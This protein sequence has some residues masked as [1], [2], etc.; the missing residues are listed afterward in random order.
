[1]TNWKWKC[2]F[3]VGYNHSSEHIDYTL[4]GS[5]SYLDIKESI[6]VVKKATCKWYNCLSTKI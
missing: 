4:S 1:M 6:K 5:L 2:T 3:S